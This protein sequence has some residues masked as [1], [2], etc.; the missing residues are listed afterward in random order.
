MQK[1][2]TNMSEN[3]FAGRWGRKC[4]EKRARGAQRIGDLPAGECVGIV[5]AAGPTRLPFLLSSESAMPSDSRASASRET[6]R[7]RARVSSVS[8]R[9]RSSSL[10]GLLY[11]SLR[12]FAHLK[13]SFSRAACPRRIKIPRP[14]SRRA[15]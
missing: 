5:K 8:I 9:S 10:F 6:E 3:R 13:T 15:R 2:E 1:G 4:G 7:A 12:V 14:R 11:T